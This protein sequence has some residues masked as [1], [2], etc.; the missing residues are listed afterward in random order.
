MSLI[1]TITD[2]SLTCK[3]AVKFINVDILL[4]N[5]NNQ[6][7]QKFFFYSANFGYV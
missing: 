1:F 2:S 3:L 5:N 4:N 7:L 6:Y